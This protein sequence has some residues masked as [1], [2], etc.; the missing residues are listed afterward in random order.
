MLALVPLIV[1]VLYIVILFLLS[2]RTCECTLRNWKRDYITGFIG[3]SLLLNLALLMTNGSKHRM[4]IVFALLLVTAAALN[5]ALMLSYS[6]DLKRAQCECAEKVRRAMT[7]L[8]VFQVSIIAFSI[9]A[10]GVTLLMLKKK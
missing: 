7:F 10:F 6:V 9:I 8:A 1:S 3:F 2:D 4:N 5:I